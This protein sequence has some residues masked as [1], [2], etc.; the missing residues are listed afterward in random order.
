M[1]VEIRPLRDEDLQH[2]AGRLR[3]MD[4]L[5]ITSVVPGQPIKRV[6]AASAQASIR[7]RTGFWNKNLVACWGVAPRLSSDHSGAPWLLATGAL[8][9]PQARRAFL[10]HSRVEALQMTEGFNYLWNFVHCEN[11]IARR[12][13]QILGFEFR[14]PRKYLFSGEPFVRFEMGTA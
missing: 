2:L 6:L 7:T 13:L 4:R 5:E 9:D 14:D 3:P 10:A 8:D 1:C 11:K 12:W